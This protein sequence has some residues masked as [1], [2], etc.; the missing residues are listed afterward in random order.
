[1]P[2][3]IWKPFSPSRLFG[4]TSIHLRSSHNDQVQ[5]YSALS[6]WHTF[7]DI[8]RTSSPP[9]RKKLKIS[10]LTGIAVACRSRSVEA[11][12]SCSVDRHCSARA[13]IGLHCRSEPRS[14]V[15]DAGHSI[16][17]AGYP[18]PLC[19]LRSV[20]IESRSILER[21]DSN[22]YIR[23]IFRIADRSHFSE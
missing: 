12:S 23:S 7:F 6:H 13:D 14:T 2:A 17:V 10:R 1:M 11:R 18:C 22:A 8:R 3:T 4:S 16:S 5:L 9:R 19:S 20:D 15:S 21:A